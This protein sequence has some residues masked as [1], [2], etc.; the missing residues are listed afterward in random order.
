MVDEDPA[1]PLFSILRSCSLSAPGSPVR[2]T[3]ERHREHC[4]E[5][6]LVGVNPALSLVLLGHGSD[7]D[8]SPSDLD[9]SLA[10]TW[11]GA[12]W[13]LLISAEAAPIRVSDGW[14][15]RQCSPDRRKTY[16]SLQTFWDGEL[17]KPMRDWIE[18]K[19]LPADVLLLKGAR[20]GG[21]T[22]AQLSSVIDASAFRDPCLFAAL[23]V[24]TPE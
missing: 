19:L 24:H 16:S 1:S 15:C 23:P 17:F 7:T 4:I 20:D 5:A 3:M 21:S 12:N 18:A 22:W 6:R 10:V 13:D 9:L 8:G 2:L 14:Q 11:G